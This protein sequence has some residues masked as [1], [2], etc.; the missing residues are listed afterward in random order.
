MTTA[1]QCPLARPVALDPNSRFACWLP[2]GRLSRARTV[3]RQ[4][5]VSFCLP[6]GQGRAN[7][8]RRPW[9]KPRRGGGKASGRVD[10]PCAPPP[11]SST[12]A[13]RTGYHE[14][15]CR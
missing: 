9:N 14:G 13:A 11:V 6:I 10:Q 2:I 1:A 5:V 3:L 4:S 8:G 7:R 15:G 12:S